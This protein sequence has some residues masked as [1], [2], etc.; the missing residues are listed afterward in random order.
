MCRFIV[1]VVVLS[2]LFFVAPSVSAEDGDSLGVALELQA[3]A[4]LTLND[5][6]RFSNEEPPLL[7]GLAGG[8]YL[9]DN[10]RLAVAGKF[11]LDANSSHTELQ[12]SATYFLDLRLVTL[13]AGLGV[14]RYWREV[15]GQDW[16]FDDQGFL[17][18]LDGG[19]RVRLVGPLSA[20]AVFTYSL[21]ESRHEDPVWAHAARAGLALS[22]KL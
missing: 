8:F 3:G 11:D 18:S 5:T 19:V 9:T 21:A 2:A 7:M 14:G 12:G 17:A 13:F 20:S 4:Q 16:T 6:A 15:G 1:P 10:L 22:L